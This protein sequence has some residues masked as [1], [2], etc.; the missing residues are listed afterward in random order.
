MNYSKVLIILNDSLLARV[1]ELIFA[2]HNFEVDIVDNPQSAL[3]LIADYKYP[4]IV[5]GDNR[6]VI[7]KN[8][9][10]ALILDK[11][12]EHKPDIVI[13]KRSTENVFPY[14]HVTIFSY[15]K[16][17]DNIASVINSIDIHRPAEEKAGPNTIIKN[18]KYEPIDNLG[19]FFHTL[20][21]NLK[22][23]FL[24]DGKRINGFIMGNEFYFIYCEF[25]KPSD[26]FFAKD[27]SVAR[28]KLDLSDIISIDSKKFNK[29]SVSC[30]IKNGINDIRDKDYFLS[31]LPKNKERIV[32][33]APQNIIRRLPMIS[34]IESFEDIFFRNDNLTFG[35]LKKQY[36]ESVD[37]LRAIAYMYMLKMI[38][39]EELQ[40]EDEYTNKKFDVKIKKGFLRKIMDKIKGL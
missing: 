2:E 21:G 19:D 26:L 36:N 4:L 25:D 34:K 39:F 28:E 24:A 14:R 8:K 30:F 10:A 7:T 9:L 6:S 15:P 32:I 11:Y 38:D 29:E 35:Y 18:R 13:F 5:I 22:M 17:H 20:K 40:P 16:L 3:S 27:I 31:L 12:D 1:L 37:I 23:D 33:K